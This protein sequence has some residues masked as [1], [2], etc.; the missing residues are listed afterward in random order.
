MRDFINLATGTTGGAS[1]AGAATG[2]LIL[3]LLTF[4]L[5]AAFGFWGAYLRWRDSKAI[6]A[7]LDA[8]DLVTA[9]KLRDKERV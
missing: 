7:A 8:G 9:L 1:L 6:R 5:F 2:Q 4:I 3:A